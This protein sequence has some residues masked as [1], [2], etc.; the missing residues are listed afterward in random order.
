MD[1]D[2]SYEDVSYSSSPESISEYLKDSHWLENH[3][4]GSLNLQSD[5]DLLFLGEVNSITR[6]IKKVCDM[7][8]KVMDDP[9]NFSNLISIV[10]S[11]DTSFKVGCANL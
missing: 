8:F 5:N 1:V 11:F 10:I 7:L 2:S 3:H 4:I 6:T 9:T